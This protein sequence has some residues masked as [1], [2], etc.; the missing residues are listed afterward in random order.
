[1]PA[2]VLVS[3]TGGSILEEA[4]ARIEALWGEMV[5][6]T[7]EAGEALY[8]SC[9]SGDVEEAISWL[10]GLP[11]DY[12]TRQPTLKRLLIADMDSTIIGCECLDELADFAGKKGDVSAITERAM[13]GEL[14]FEAA[15]TARVAMLAGLNLSALQDCYDARVTINPGAEIF[16]RTMTKL[17]AHC[18]LVSGGFS[19]FTTKVAEAVGFHSQRANIL[20][21]EGNLLTGKV[22]LPILGKEAKLLALKEDAARLGLDLD[23]TIAIGDGANDLMMIE[24]AGLGIAYRAK[25]IVAAKASARIEYGTLE[26]AL[27]FQGI[28]RRDFVK[29]DTL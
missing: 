17:G 4:V 3:P 27:F 16:V 28:R 18:A 26:S 11:L 14:D 9:Q 8:V 29:P 1:M 20:M 25:P 23:Q 6:T 2:L 15:L 24:A 21:V 10:E 13:A 19:F 5:V 7:I 12:S 22:R